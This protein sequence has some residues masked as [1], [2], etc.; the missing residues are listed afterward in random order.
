MGQVISC[1]KK[2]CIVKWLKSI[3]Q[4]EPWGKNRVSA[5]LYL[6][7]ILVSDVKKFLPKLLHTMV[8]TW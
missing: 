4:G 5:F 3:V 6:V 7:S 2:S 8:T 1:E